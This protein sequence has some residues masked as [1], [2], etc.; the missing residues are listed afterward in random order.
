MSV[1]TTVAAAKWAKTVDTIKRNA[2]WV[3]GGL[4]VFGLSYVMYSTMNRPVAGAL[5][6]VG[7]GLILFYYWIKWFV[8]PPVPDED[9][10]PVQACPDYLSLIT[11]GELY[12]AD[13][14]NGTYYCVEFVGVSR[15]GVLK[16]IID[17]AKNIQD[18]AYHFKVYPN[19]DFTQKGR[20]EFMRRLIKAGLSW[21]SIGA[22]SSPSRS[23][24]NGV[25]AAPK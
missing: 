11:P 20:R 13:P 4:V 14:D 16:K 25:P 8:V 24:N 23:N 1:S 2:F 5:T 10:N 7:G 15:N 21:N 6:F 17:L 19:R 12:P 18:P 22:N 3:V 9:F